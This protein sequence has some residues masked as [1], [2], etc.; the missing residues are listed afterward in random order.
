MYYGVELYMVCGWLRCHLV[1]LPRCKIRKYELE[2]DDRGG[3][4]PGKIR[5]A[6]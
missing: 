1:V 4:D 6:F 2:S 3:G 5:I